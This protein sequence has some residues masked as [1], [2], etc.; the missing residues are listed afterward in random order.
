M[1]IFVNLIHRRADQRETKAIIGKE[2]LT[3]QNGCMSTVVWTTFIFCLCL[4]MIKDSCS[5]LHTS[6]SQRGLVGCWCSENLFMFTFNRRTPRPSDSAKAIS[7]PGINHL[8]IALASTGVPVPEPWLLLCSPTVSTEPLSHSET[9]RGVLTWR[10]LEETK[11]DV[12]SSAMTPF[13][14]QLQ[15][16]CSCCC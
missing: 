9:D 12:P 4:D 3:G 15:A 2:A 7:L 5:C 6:W 10:H 13:L 8:V 1:C 16:C 14:P 11:T